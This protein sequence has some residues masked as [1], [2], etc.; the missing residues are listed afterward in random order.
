M[1]IASAIIISILVGY[2]L[3]SISNGVLIGKIFYGVD[4]R[5]KGSGNSGGTNTGRV[6]GKKAG[7]ST[8]ILD[9]LKTMIS[10]W[11][12]L[13]IYRIPTI[14]DLIR[15]DPSYLSFIAGFSCCIGHTYPIFFNF[16]G[17]KSVACLAG[18][19]L[20]TNWIIS[21]IGLAIFMIVLL[22]SKYVSLSSCIA[23][24]SV[25][26]MSFIPFICQY[27]T[28]FNINEY[29]IIFS[30]FYSLVA[31]LLIFRHKENISRLIKGT[32]SKIT[33]LNKKN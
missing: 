24:I 21:I 16:K 17:G 33:W 3:G 10:M 31:L 18:I 28:I 27:G 2:L 9:A 12:I 19:C 5:Q 7:I 6:L 14:K 13:F 15:I 20:A 26:I 30:I 22:I 11:L 1:I 25:A 32:E 23:A 8:I 4:V 29:N